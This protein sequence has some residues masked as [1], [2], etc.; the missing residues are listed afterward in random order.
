MTEQSMFVDANVT[1]NVLSGKYKDKL[2]FILV[3]FSS[4]IMSVVIKKRV[5]TKTRIYATLQ[6]NKWELTD[7]SQ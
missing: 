4:A 7:Y 3:H 1:L 2:I 6:I 5:G